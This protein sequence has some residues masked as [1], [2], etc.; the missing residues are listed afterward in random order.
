MYDGI[1]SYFWNETERWTNGYALFG[2]TKTHS[3]S[4]E[5]AYF[6]ETGQTI[7]A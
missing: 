7:S 4:C 5:T 3:R 6:L 1:L 2:T